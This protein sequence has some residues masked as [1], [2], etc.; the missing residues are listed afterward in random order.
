MTELR[1]E[2]HD[3]RPVA[4][5]ILVV[6]DSPTIRKV[7]CSILRA[8]HYEPISAEDGQDA[9][10]KLAH[11]EVDLVLLDFVMP[12]MNGYQF[13]R[14]IRARPELRHLPVVLMSAK[15]D[16]IR[17]HFVQQTGAIDAITKPFDARGLATVVEEALRK[18]QEGRARPLPD[19]EAMPE[20]DSLVSQTANSVLT[21][22]DRLEREGRGLQ[23]F[24]QALVALVERSLHSGPS[25][26]RTL[27]A[28]QTE[29][30]PETLWE[31]VNLAKAIPGDES[32]AL[33]GDIGVISIAEILQLLQLQRQSGAL[34][35]TSR[36]R[37]ISLFVRDGNIDLGTSHGLPGEFLLGRYL[38]ESG[39]ISR[40]E[41]ENVLAGRTHVGPSG[42]WLVHLGLVNEDQVQHALL[43]QT[44]EL[45]FECVRWRDGRFRFLAGISSPE[46]AKARLA[47]ATGALMLEGFRR[48]DEWRLIEDSF[49]F[50]DVLRCDP[51]ALE[52]LGDPAALTPMERAVLGAI[53]GQRTIR[54]IVDAI[55]GSSF[56]LSK[57]IYQFLN[58]RAV[59]RV[60]R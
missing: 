22:R 23:N 34:T 40:A 56:E 27:T 57:I 11:H 35:I 58:S 6:D 60:G 28:L 48:V 2:L 42:E 33:A 19:A 31:L 55:E 4:A 3:P 52:Q 47:L 21:T 16:K 26:S 54:E 24:A 36:R 13:C 51:V 50:E 32:E 17:G 10:D 41:L 5:R 44:S 53:D 39:V 30:S 38:V 43:R 1:R 14:L 8:R 37:Q 59:R 49:G 46:S 18:H 45:V 15:G 20:E 9:L 25:S 29:L 7:V 12:R